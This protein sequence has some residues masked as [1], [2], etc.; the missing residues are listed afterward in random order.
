MNSYSKL[1]WEFT[2][3][4][5]RVEFM[6]LTLAITTTGIQLSLYVKELNLYLYIP[7]SL[8]TQLVTPQVFHVASSSE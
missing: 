3:L 4:S 8:C 1:T 2:P 5:K 7:P 6:D